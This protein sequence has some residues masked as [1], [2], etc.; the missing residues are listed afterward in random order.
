MSN[1]HE[2]RARIVSIRDIMKITN[3]MYLISSSKLKK[4]RKDLAATEP[5][6]NK[7][8]YA[9]RS[10]L[11]RAPEEIKMQYFDQRPQIPESKRKI[12]LL[13]ITADKGMCGSYNHNVIK[14][15]ESVLNRTDASMLYVIGQVGRMYF[16]R[17]ANEGKL[18]VDPQFV[19]TTQNPT[20]YRARS[21]AEMMLDRF[22][23]GEVDDFYIVYTKMINSM[24]YE[25]CVQH[26]LPLSVH[27]FVTDAEHEQTH[28][29]QATFYPTVNAVMEHLIP[30]FMKGLVYGAMVESFC[31][32]QQARMTAMDS[33]TSSAKDMLQSLSLQY[34]RARQAAITQEISEVCSGSNA[35]QE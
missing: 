13:I 23:A 16:Q 17:K 5:Y 27:N 15:A 22:T 6:F 29:H 3:A 30:N 33:A 9:M 28:H 11:S 4:A 21:I 10:I 25:P 12:G 1:M 19:Y 8:T 34:N 2:I 26:L 7:L 20:L 31:S 18:E 35:L 32:E 24:T 14:L